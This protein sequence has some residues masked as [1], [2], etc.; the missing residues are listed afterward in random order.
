MKLALTFAL[1]VGFTTVVQASDNSIE[2]TLE[3]TPGDQQAQRKV[4]VLD[5]YRHKP[6]PQKA[7]SDANYRYWRNKFEGGSDKPLGRPKDAAAIKAL[8][9][10]TISPTIRWVSRSI[11]VVSAD[12]RSPSVL[13]G[14]C[15]YVFEKHGSQWSLTHHYHWPFQFF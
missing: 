12:C 4:L 2:V 13:G 14:R 15:L 1:I 9:P 7:D 5:A 11:V 6:P 3:R 8:V 10:A